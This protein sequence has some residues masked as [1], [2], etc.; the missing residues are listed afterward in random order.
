MPSR[1]FPRLILLTVVAVGL[2][3]A[4]AAS[5]LNLSS[6]FD[7]SDEGWQ[8]AVGQSY[9]FGAPGHAATGGN[10]NGFI[11]Y[12]QPA[13]A[14]DEIYAW[15]VSPAGWAGDAL[16]NYGG[17]VGFDARSVP[18]S[19]QGPS[20]FQPSVYL[21]TGTWPPGTGEQTVFENPGPAPL[22]S[23]W[24]QYA[25][26]LTTSN[27]NE[28][29]DQEPGYEPTD[30]A[31]FRQVLHNL[32]GVAIITEGWIGVAEQSGLDNPLL[33]GGQSPPPVEFERE[34]TIRYRGGAFT[35]TLT[36]NE[37]ACN[38]SGV[39]VEV[40]RKKR[41]PDRSIGSDDTDGS[42]YAV[43]AARREGRY[44]A[45]APPHVYEGLGITCAKAKSPTKTIR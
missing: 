28:V 21:F 18:D 34:L 3:P 26:P 22:S 19:P 12:S 39:P 43:E 4:T 37:T 2:C 13:P 33:S 27:W 31:Y 6:N 44:Y 41:G 1:L 11:F 36:S 8:L 42:E 9:T 5:A 40:F 35:G 45:K 32:G 14:P 30:E 23:S 17:T 25:V 10:P 15:F 16:P 29:T 38:L 20:Q 7:S 24:S